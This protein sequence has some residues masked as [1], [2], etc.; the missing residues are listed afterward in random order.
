MLNNERE[1]KA[2][3]QHLLEGK[4]CKKCAGV[5]LKTHDEFLNDIRIKQPTVI[6]LDK[7][8]NNHT[9]ILVR[10]SQCGNEWY[11]KPS[12]LLS[13]YGCK[14]CANKKRADKARLTQEQFL[15]KMKEKGDPN[16]LIIGN[17]YSAKTEI[18]CRCKKCGNIWNA[19]PN[20]L[21]QDTVVRNVMAEAQKKCS[22]LQPVR[23]LI[24]FLT[25]K[26]NMI[27]KERE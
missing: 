9:N 23:F 26:R 24:Q 3:P 18:R 8:V 27:L 17:Y 13:G 14:E 21:L 15:A 12:N 1:M 6:V 7:Y 2:S 4:G 10:C 11:A 5:E 20:S 22:V 16:V 25:L 19:T